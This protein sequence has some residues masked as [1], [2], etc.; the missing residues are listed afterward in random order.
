MAH[1]SINKGLEQFKKSEKG[2]Y[3]MCSTVSVRARGCHRLQ[4]SPC[5]SPCTATVVKV[6]VG[7]K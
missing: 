6:H 1:H 5:R 3:L 2:Y 4:Y 7:Q